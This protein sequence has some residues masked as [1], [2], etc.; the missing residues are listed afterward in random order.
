M[1]PE[2]GNRVT[3]IPAAIF[4]AGDYYVENFKRNEFIELLKKV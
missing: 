4:Q 2:I 1:T 3:G